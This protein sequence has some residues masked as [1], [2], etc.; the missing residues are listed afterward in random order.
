MTPSAATR[1]LSNFGEARSR[2]DSISQYFPTVYKKGRRIET[3]GGDTIFSTTNDPAP[4]GRSPAEL[5]G[6]LKYWPH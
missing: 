5:N 2:L 6:K 1:V 4:R 3:A